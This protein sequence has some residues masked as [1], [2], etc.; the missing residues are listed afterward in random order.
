MDVWEA[1]K[2]NVMPLKRGR[3]IKT[4]NENLEK[5]LKHEKVEKM[6]ENIFEEKIKTSNTSIDLL[7]SYINYVKWTRDTFPSNADKS[8]KLLEV[9]Y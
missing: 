3:S 6:H 5:P 1:S 8:L 7:A 2:E 4:L 9:F